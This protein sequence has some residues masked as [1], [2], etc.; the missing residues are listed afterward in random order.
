[1]EVLEKAR[2]LILSQIEDLRISFLPTVHQLVLVR[3][4]IVQTA[5]IYTTSV[6]SKVES[7][8]STGL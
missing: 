6:I 3:S 8:T 7:Q 4:V 2:R 5:A 1:M